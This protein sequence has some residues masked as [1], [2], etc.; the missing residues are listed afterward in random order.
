MRTAYLASQ[1]AGSDQGAETPDWL[2]ERL[3]AEFGFDFDPCPASW[4]PGC[5]WSGLEVAWGACTYVNPPFDAC[6]AWL[7]KGA[8]EQ[9]RGKTSVFLIPARPWTIYWRDVVWEYASEVRI[10]D[11]TVAFKGY[12]EQLPTAL[13]LV[14]FYGASAPLRM[15]DRPSRQARLL[16]AP[17]GSLAG[18]VAMLRSVGYELPTVLIGPLVPLTEAV[19]QWQRAPEQPLVLVFAARLESRHFQSAVLPHADDLYFATPVLK[20]DQG[21][22]LFTGSCVAVFDRDLTRRAALSAKATHTLLVSAYDAKRM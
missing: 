5:E 3:H 1:A 11:Q 4:H 20:S 14:I 10:L 9:A 7:R 6:E 18:L 17:E 12:K 13:A 22:R 16:P 2:L 8:A 19:A 15:L 21:T